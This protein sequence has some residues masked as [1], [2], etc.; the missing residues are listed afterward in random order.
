LVYDIIIKNGRIIDGAGNPW[1]NADLGIGNGLIKKVGR[2]KEKSAEKT[3][4]ASGM[5][6]CP[7]FIDP[8]SHS[9]FVLP[10]DA[11]LESTIRQGIT[12]SIVGNCGYSL[13]PVNPEKLEIFEKFMGIFIPKDEKLEINWHYFNE[14]QEKMEVIGSS[15]NIVPLVGFGTI[16]I[17]G[18]PGYEAREPT[19]KELES[20]KNYVK[21]AME[22]GAFGFSTGLIYTPQTFA[23][24]EEVIE[25]ARVAAHYGG[26][27]FS[28]IRNE[29]GAVIDAIK[30]FIDIVKKSGCIGGQI[31]H[32]KVSGKPYWGS[33]KE[34]IRLI[35]E[36]NHMMGLNITADQYPYSRGLSSLITVLPP[37]VH[38]GGMEKILERL[39]NS[40]DRKRM[41]R[42]INQGLSGWENWVRDVGFNRIFLASVKTE[43]NQA[44]EGKRLDEISEIRG[45]PDE[46]STLY[47]LLLEENA[48]ITMTV[49]SMGDEDIRNIMKG[50]FT[51]I[52]TDGWGVS[53]TGKLSRGGL[54]HP[55]F[56]GTFP[57]VLA[58]YVREEKLLSLEEAIRK[59]TGFTAQ[60]I[61]LQDRG[62]IREGMAADIVV[63][64]PENVQDNATFENPHQFPTGIKHVIVNG[65]LVV[66][67]E[68]QNNNMPG[69]LLRRSA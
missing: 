44:L 54:P 39:R 62:L 51:V 58:K 13:A 37:W 5:I 24:T 10:F 36:A 9:D 28:H 32:K 17:A 65:V 23:R 35:N 60:R 29:G 43:K 22:S 56:Y 63:F 42:D 25:L 15:A 8:H 12:T 47:D 21:E 30:E 16:R 3:L 46:F 19:A 4:D 50:K 31:A 48:E 57:R 38:E 2:L 66:E 40:E 55:R 41:T 7:G 68:K 64:D 33:S 20:M 52:G 1:I 11:R 45:D 14:Y 61:G 27:Y 34:T 53:P 49:A 69:K 18:G 6:V 67:N 59:M 26:L